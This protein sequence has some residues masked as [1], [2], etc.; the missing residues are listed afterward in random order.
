MT[1]KQFGE[2]G[3]LIQFENIIS[4]QIHLLVSSY[5]QKLIEVSFDGLLSII[6]AYNSITIVFNSSITDFLS[7]RKKVEDLDIK[8]KT[9]TDQK[10]IE[11]PVC[12]DPSLGLDIEFVANHNALT[13]NDI[14]QLHTSPLYTVYMLGFSPGFMYLGGLDNKL[15]IPRKE[16]PR[17]KISAGA[18]GLA[19][20]Q[21]GIYPSAT[22]GGWQIIGQTP[23]SIFK[24]N[25]KPL[26]Q[27]GDLVKFRPIDLETYNQMSI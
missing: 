10:V 14:I 17:L 8:I 26:V 24:L 13:I 22:P 25:E 12:Y 5:Y 21:T 11:I 4:T 7:I 27:M 1:I 9:R 2:N 23:L 20:K 15:F 16:N 19:D 18:V 3:L 6:P